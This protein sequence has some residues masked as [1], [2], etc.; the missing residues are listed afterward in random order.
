MIPVLIGHDIRLTNPFRAAPISPITNE[1][2]YME[3]QAA[4]SLLLREFVAG[5][6]NFA[7]QNSD[8]RMGLR[9]S[10]IIYAHGREQRGHLGYGIAFCMEGITQRTAPQFL[11]LQ[12]AFQAVYLS[13]CGGCAIPPSPDNQRVNNGDAMCRELARVMGAPVF[14]SANFQMHPPDVQ[15]IMNPGGWWPPVYRYSP[16]GARDRLDSGGMPDPAPGNYR[17]P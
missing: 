14:A 9:P 16:D 4:G 3:M 6:A 12:N 8:P 2:T 10:L 11:P 13:A 7:R 15:F 5:A 1:R 17:R